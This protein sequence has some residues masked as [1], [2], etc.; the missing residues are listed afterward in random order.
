METIFD[1]IEPFGKFLTILNRYGIT[2]GDVKY[3]EAY[4]E[5]LKL[6]GE[7]HTY[8]ASLETV[9]E[10]HGLPI[11]TLRGKFKIFSTRLGI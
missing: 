9:S 7:G 10:R 8:Y 11:G 6:R 5:F 3:F 4:R 1:F 2:P